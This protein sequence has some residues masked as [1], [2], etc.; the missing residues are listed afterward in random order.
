MAFLNNLLALCLEAA[1]WLVL[2][3]I[4]GGLIKALIPTSLLQRHLSGNN[5]QSVVKAA[6]FGAPLPL[7][8]CGVIPAAL[9]LRRAGASKPATVSFLVAT[10]E[11][12]ID[13]V[14]ISYAL[15]GPFMAIVRPIAAIISAVTAGLLVGKAEE[16]DVSTHLNANENTTKNVNS[17][18][19]TTSC[20]NTAVEPVQTSCCDSSKKTEPSVETSSCC[21][22][23]AKSS[24]DSAQSK[25]ME[26]ESLSYTRS[27]F[28]KAWEGVVYSFT[29]LFDKVLFW[30]MI[31]LVFA[32]LVQTFVPVSFLAEWGTGL[33][34]MLLMLVVG[35]PMYVCATASTPIAAGLLLAGVSPGTAMV[36]LMAGPATNISTIGVIGKELG[37]RALIAYLSGVTIVALITGL[38]VDYLVA[39]FNIDIQGQISHSHEMV[40]SV[41]AWVSLLLL[42]AVVL[43][44]KLGK[45]FPWAKHAH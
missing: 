41:I 22:S 29:D 43:K 27:F 12:G 34:A 23:I 15:L 31:G 28:H 4:I 39:T 8:S 33:P 18:N 25:A 44:L 2:G 24:N 45:Y 30:L 40:P 6:L 7:C 17:T 21:D 13:S 11:T 20:C 37:R 32:T 1:P 5:T 3:L 36:F 16:T 10:P 35:I 19:V 42:V 14:S 26:A 9:G 38:L